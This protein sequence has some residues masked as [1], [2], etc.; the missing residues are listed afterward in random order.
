MYTIHNLRIKRSNAPG[1]YGC[2]GGEDTLILSL[3][4]LSSHYA[5]TLQGSVHF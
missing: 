5:Q 1:M 3:H 2:L 4:D